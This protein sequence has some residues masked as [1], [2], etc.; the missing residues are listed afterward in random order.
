MSFPRYPKYKDSGVEWLGEVP[1][2]WR[3]SPLKAVATHNDDVLDEATAPE[4][5]ILYV[6]I[7]G[8]HN[9]EEGTLTF[10]AINRHG[11]EILNVEIDLQGFGAATIIDH[12]V[13]TH[14]SLDAINSLAQQSNVTPAK[15][16]G[17]RVAD[18][19]AHLN[20]PPHSYQMLRLKV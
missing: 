4:T 5:E 8:V 20:L 17:A 9:D 11:S 6:D 2:Q 14:T 15:G 7:S 16:N 19:S 18:G 1:E 13:M 12:Q 10:F 3:V